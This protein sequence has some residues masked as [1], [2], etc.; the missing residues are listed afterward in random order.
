[1]CLRAPSPSVAGARPQLGITVAPSD[2]NS[3]DFVKFGEP[4]LVAVAAHCGGKAEADTADSPL[5]VIDL[6]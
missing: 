5:G 2:G 3:L 4:S 6:P 1:M